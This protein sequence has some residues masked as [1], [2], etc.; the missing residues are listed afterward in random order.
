MRT[1]LARL[2]YDSHLH[3]CFFC[4][5]LSCIFFLSW[6]DQ[7]DTDASCSHQ[8]TVNTD[9]GF[10]IRWTRSPPSVF[11]E[12]FLEDQILSF[13]N[14]EWRHRRWFAGTLKRDYRRQRVYCT[15]VSSCTLCYLAVALTLTG[16]KW[17]LPLSSTI[18][19]PRGLPNCCAG[20][21]TDKCFIIYYALVFHA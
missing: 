5:L 18:F 19:H 11:W 16:H 6:R 8:S 21:I 4:N 7:R 13:S 17:Q 12:C 2:S 3:D 15:F 20:K 14:W 9:T 1:C 10:D